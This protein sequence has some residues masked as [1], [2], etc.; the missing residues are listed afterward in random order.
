MG[1]AEHN[2]EE[3][4]IDKVRASRNGHTGLHKPGFRKRGK[5]LPENR[6][7]N[8]PKATKANEVFQ[9]DIFGRNQ[10]QILI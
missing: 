9:F 5:G 6:I 7:T 8:S 1:M 3:S 2:F 4:Q 10:R